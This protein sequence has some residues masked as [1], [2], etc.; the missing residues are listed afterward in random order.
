MCIVCQFIYIS[1]ETKK[2]MA[3]RK[4]RLMK[5]EIREPLSPLSSNHAAARTPKARHSSVRTPGAKTPVSKKSHGATSNQDGCS[6]DR[7]IPNRALMDAQV[8]YA[9]IY[10]IYVN[11]SLKITCKGGFINN[12]RI[13]LA[14][15]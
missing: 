15:D 5:G 9:F 6:Y 2:N 1:L 8:C 11:C 4:M 7:F 12:Y 10:S 13:Y 3:E 14:I